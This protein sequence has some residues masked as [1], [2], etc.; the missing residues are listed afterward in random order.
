MDF[1]TRLNDLAAKKGYE[2]NSQLAK[3][4]GVP[5]TTL[6]NFYR[7]GYENAKLSTLKKLA[8]CLGCSL[9]YLVNGEDVF[10]NTAALADLS[11]RAAASPTV[12]REKV[13]QLKER[14]S[15]PVS[16][17]TDATSPD[18]L[19]NLLCKYEQLDEHGRQIVDTVLD[20]EYK[21]CSSD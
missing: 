4:S 10:P 21:R 5:Y 19:F 15:H 16:D 12:L 14:V 9:E 13:D 3:A 20:I 2:N 6:D 18:P 11:A 17:S 8:S 1:L 7:N